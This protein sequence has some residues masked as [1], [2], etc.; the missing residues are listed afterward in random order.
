VSVN[1]TEIT[2]VSQISSIVRNAKIGSTI[3]FKV[4]RNK[5]EITVSVSVY[6]Y[7]PN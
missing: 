4:I 5:A 3:E 1:G 7:A 6:E 2:E